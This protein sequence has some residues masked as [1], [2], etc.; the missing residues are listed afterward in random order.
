VPLV[1]RDTEHIAVWVPEPSHENAR[2][3][4]PYPQIVLRQTRNANELNAGIPQR[5]DRR[6]D[7]RHFPAKDRE[8]LRPEILHCRNAQ[9]CAIRVK[10]SRIVIFVFHSQAKGANLKGLSARSVTQRKHP[11]LALPRID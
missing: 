6:F 10:H 5:L 2:S 3:R 9:R 7:L 4:R 11:A 1:L 8:G